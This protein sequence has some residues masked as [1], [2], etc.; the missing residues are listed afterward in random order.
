MAPG[1]PTEFRHE[2]FFY[3][4]PDQFFGGILPFVE[5]A[6][7]S[8]EP[9]LVILDANKIDQ[10]RRHISDASRVEFADMTEVGGNPGRIIPL[11]LDF[12]DRHADAASSLFGV[13]EPIG[14]DREGE[15]LSECQVH[16]VLINVAFEESVP[17]L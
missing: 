1:A 15:E 7:A 6:V 4:S 11:W 8:G 10:I 13:G 14:P 12:V 5:S 16:E 2:A 9:A 3:D 17:W